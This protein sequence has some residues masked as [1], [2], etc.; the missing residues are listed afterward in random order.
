MDWVLAPCDTRAAR[1]LAEEL[2]V[3]EIAA[4]VLIRRGHDDAAS[5]TTFLA[6]EPPGHDAELLGDVKGACQL[7]H[8]AIADG[9]RI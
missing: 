8:T 6:G 7:I 9:T 5:A 2:G 1:K 3:S 4:R